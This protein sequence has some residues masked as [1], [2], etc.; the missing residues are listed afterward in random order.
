MNLSK[1]TEIELQMQKINLWLLGGGK[2]RGERNWE[3]I[4]MWAYKLGLTYTQSYI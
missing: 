2:G 1:K 3:I 4:Y